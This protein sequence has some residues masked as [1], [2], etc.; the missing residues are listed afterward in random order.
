[1]SSLGFLHLQDVT[2]DGLLVRKTTFYKSHRLSLHAITRVALDHYLCHRQHVAET[3]AY[4]FVSRR[5]GHS[6]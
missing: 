2:A 5:H 1:M 3:S 4:L 6:V